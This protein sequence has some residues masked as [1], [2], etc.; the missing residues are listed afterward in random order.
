MV[1][2]KIN[3]FKSSNRYFL[4]IPDFFE[5]KIKKIKSKDKI[6]RTEQIEKQ[7]TKQIRYHGT[8]NVKKTEN[9][10]F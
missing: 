7:R 9:D 8:E 5:S 10:K 6:Q 2:V 4:L 3:N 1:R